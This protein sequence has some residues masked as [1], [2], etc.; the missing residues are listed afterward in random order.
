M[1]DFTGT[2]LWRNGPPEKPVLCNACGS[3]YRLGKPLE[4]YTPKSVIVLRKKKRRRAVPK[5]MVT[6]QNT[7]VASSAGYASNLQRYASSESS[8]SHDQNLLHMNQQNGA[9]IP[10]ENWESLW[11]SQV[12]SRSRSPVLYS[13]VTSIKKLQMD[14]HNILR[15]EGPFIASEGPEDVL[16]YND[17]INKLQIP[18]T[19][20]GLGSILLKF[21]A[22]DCQEQEIEP[23][24]SSTCGKPSALN[25]VQIASPSLNM[26]EELQRQWG[27]P[28]ADQSFV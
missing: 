13:R 5:A 2:P 22:T 25:D 27:Q 17:N 11:G 7:I 26:I 8:T 9:E 15:D 6:Q 1:I 23:A 21:P 14:L 16:I 19:E 28:T 12:P 10:V 20:I 4:N 24:S 18:S 3:R